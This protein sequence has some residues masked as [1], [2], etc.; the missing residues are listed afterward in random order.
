M[1]ADEILAFMSERFADVDVVV[2]GEENGAPPAAWG[3]AF[4]TYAPE[5]AAGEGSE[6]S[7]PRW[8]FVTVV[9]QDYEGFDTASS[10]DREGGRVP[11]E[12]VGRS[13]GLR[14]GAG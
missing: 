12:R 13:Q 6:E 7:T 1:T 9:T 14:R 11:P 8:P 10:L 4:C 2:A 3:D 5:T